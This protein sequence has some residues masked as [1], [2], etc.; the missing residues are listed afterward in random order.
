MLLGLAGCVV[1][2]VG[3]LADFARRGGANSF[4]AFGR[5]PG[6]DALVLDVPFDR[7][8][9]PIACGAHLLA[10]VIRYWRPVETVT[11]KS[12]FASR[13]PA[14]AK[15]G[16][17][18][19]ELIS[20]AG[21]HGLSAYGVRIAEP[22][23]VAELE[24]GRPVLVPLLLPGVYEQT[25]SFFDPDPAGIAQLKAWYLGAVGS[26]SEL[27]KAG[28]LPHYVL[29]VGHAD[30][31]FVLLDPVLGYRTIAKARLARYRA[32]YEGASLIFSPKVAS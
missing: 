24:K 25:A 2:P 19:Q 21:E 26:A 23:L 4:E 32:S 7:Q 9:N 18:M 20:L 5:V 6:S 17:S 12:I 8:V 3:S 13:P 28:L 29:V 30:D 27:L 10:S 11:G 14:D 31:R 15:V 1:S 16:Y 22:D